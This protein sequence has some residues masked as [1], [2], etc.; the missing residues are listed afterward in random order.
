MQPNP[1][2][3]RLHRI[4]IAASLAVLPIALAGCSTNDDGDFSMRA[5]WHDQSH[6]M[7]MM[8]NDGSRPIDMNE[9]MAG[10]RM[11]GP[12]GTIPMY[13]GGLNGTSEYCWMGEDQA[14]MHGNMGSW[15]C[16]HWGGM[17]MHTQGSMLQPGEAWTYQMHAMNASGGWGMMM[18]PASMDGGWM[19]HGNGNHMMLA[20]GDYEWHMGR[21]QTSASLG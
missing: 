21:Y 18:M 19:L 9:M 16:D 12:N 17:P 13:W 2:P 10:I 3:R 8:R 20:S 7:I 4:A 6:A 1:N 11:M 14:G 5:D 15:P